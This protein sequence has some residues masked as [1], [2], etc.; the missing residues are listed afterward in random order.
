MQHQCHAIVPDIEKCIRES[1]INK[2][3][4]ILAIENGWIQLLSIFTTYGLNL[5]RTSGFL[6]ELDLSN[7]FAL[8]RL[9]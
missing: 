3:W 5:Y 4:R 8:L 7:I 2:E 9:L 6:K 1:I